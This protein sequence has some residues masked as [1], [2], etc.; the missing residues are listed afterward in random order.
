MGG[1]RTCRQA[2]VRDRQAEFEQPA[3]LSR[4]RP[5]RSEASRPRNENVYVIY[6]GAGPDAWALLPC[7][8][9][10]RC[11]LCVIAADV[12]LQAAIARRSR[13]SKAMLNRARRRRRPSGNAAGI[14]WRTRPRPT[15]PL[16]NGPTCQ[17]R[18]KR[19]AGRKAALPQ[20][21]PIRRHSASA[22]A[23]GA[24]RSALERCSRA[25]RTWSRRA[26]S[27]K[28]A[29]SH[30][31]AIGK[32]ERFRWPN[33][34]IRPGAGRFAASPSATPKS[35]WRMLRRDQADIKAV[36]RLHPAPRPDS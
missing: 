7:M 2:C 36:C 27:P 32:S 4:S 16:S 10:A 35:R 22:K 24:G 23:R 19:K 14:R 30:Q 26:N 31:A 20:M 3:R 34:I 6:S 11:V 13:R 8:R 29:R 28:R 9:I 17:P 15:R 25:R 33:R 1:I 12:D 21:R 5:S 18:S